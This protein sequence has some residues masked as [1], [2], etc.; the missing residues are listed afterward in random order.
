[1]LR[2]T[3]RELMVGPGAFQISGSYA[4]QAMFSIETSYVLNRWFTWGDRSTSISVSLL[5][6]N[7]QRVGLTIPNYLGFALLVHLGV[8]WLAANLTVTAVFTAVNFVL[9][10][11]WSFRADAAATTML[12]P[13]RALPPTLTSY[14]TVSVVIP[15]KSNEGTIGAT[16]ESILGQDYPGL[17][18]LIIVGDVGDPT[19]RGLSHI[20]DPR[21]ILLEQGAEP[22]LRDPNIKRDKGL[23]KATGDLLALAD[24]DI[25]MDRDWLSKAVAL[26]LEQRGGVVAGGMR[27]IENTF[28]GRFVDANVIAAKTPRLPVPYYVTATNFGRSG[29][30]PPISA[31]TVFAREVY[32]ATPLDPTWYY[33]YEDYEWFWRVAR[34]G[35]KILFT[36]S[37][38]GAHHH[39]RSFGKLVKEYRRAA[40]GCAHFIRAHRGSPLARKRLAQA[41]T[42]PPTALAIAGLA[43]L[44]ASAGGWQPVAAAAFLT[45]AA[46]AVREVARAR[47]LEA[48]TYPVIGLALAGIFTMS[49]IRNL[50]V[51]TTQPTTRVTTWDDK[52]PSA[53]AQRTTS[54]PWPLVAILAVQAGLSLSLVWSNTAFGDEA[55]YLS[56]GRLELLHW[57]HGIVIP[58][59]ASRPFSGASQIY[60]PIGALANAVGGLAAARI[61]SLCFMLL[62]TVLLYLVTGR[63]AGIRAAVAGCA[64]WALSEPVL[65]LA[66][67]TYDPLACLLVIL[68]AWLAVQ[69]A[70][71]S[72]RGEL[73]ALSALSLA[74][75]SVTAFSFAIYIPVVVLFAFFTWRYL[76]G[77]RQALWCGAWLGLTAIVTAA[78]LM[79]FLHLWAA[80]VSD[81][82]A[83]P[84]SKLG[85]S[86]ALVA[87]SAWSFDGLL[88]GIACAGVILA[89]A[90]RDQRKWIFASCV[91]AG[92]VVPAYQSYIG[93]AG[94]I[95]KHL[96]AGTALL[97]IAAGFAFSWVTMPG[98]RRGA[99]W[100]LAAA[101]LA[102]PAITGLWYARSTFHAWPD[103]APVLRSLS[104]SMRGSSSPVLVDSAHDFSV[105]EFDYYLTRG[106]D[107]RQ[108]QTNVADLAPVSAGTYSTVVLSLNAGGLDSPGLAA[109]ALSRAPAASEVLRLAG[110][111][112]LVRTLIS[113]RK[114]RIYAVIPYQTS[115]STDLSGVFVVWQRVGSVT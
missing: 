16:A 18:E 58:A 43:G 10:D 95:D 65:R 74:L 110:N 46:L 20:A 83:R 6:W 96:S 9:G 103:V 93:T 55:N 30:R 7:V 64:L 22:G 89:F 84:A 77:P 69:A 53:Q 92:I 76:I 3:W 8:S 86:V 48:V 11:K 109:G 25:V 59:A 57:L 31:N 51:P 80:A 85:Q 115:N 52:P 29:M 1:M 78:A 114:Y 26:L 21:M 27:S 39:R 112:A 60:P 63:L 113:S 14:P 100:A 104:G 34:D 54:V 88:F 79:T 70:V 37:L 94:S 67:A 72:R 28:W 71:R 75:G 97:A 81:T 101:L 91:I 32:D 56:Y 40:E 66:F 102:F 87:R 12:P 82:V 5:R 44:A 38:N 68:S 111:D 107:W 4:V 19:W 62:S 2:R 108:W 33:G 45:L 24:S 106:N 98:L 73:V 36:G 15:C 47:R 99:A 23:R 42:L 13:N 61:L 35:H 17:T 105:F 41:V 50:I 90:V 49:L